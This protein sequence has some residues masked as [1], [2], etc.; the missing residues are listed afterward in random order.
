MTV[1]L[2]SN[3]PRYQTADI[4]QMLKK[5]SKSCL[6]MYKN[7]EMLGFKFDEQV[8]IVIICFEFLPIKHCVIL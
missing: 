4:V 8:S 7:I 5:G 6:N 3:L 2:K 1:I